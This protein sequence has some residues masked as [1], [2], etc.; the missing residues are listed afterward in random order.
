MRLLDTR[1]GLLA[2][3][4]EAGHAQTCPALPATEAALQR[5]EWPAYAG[6]NGALRWSPL[7]RID[8]SNASR[9]QV[10]WRWRSPD[11]ALRD[12]SPAS[13]PPSPTN[14]RRSWW[15]ARSM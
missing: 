7:D 1:P 10:V 2:A 11:H 4:A 15:A 5:G 12:A 3:G 14:R 9:L 8:R 6:S 13:P